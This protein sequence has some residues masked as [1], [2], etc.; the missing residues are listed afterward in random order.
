MNLYQLHSNPESLYGY[1]EAPYRIP[2]IAYEL[3]AKKYRRTGQRDPK[4]ESVIAQ[5]PYRAYL[6]AH[7]F[8]RG[9]WPEGER[10]IAQ[11]PGW[12]CEYALNIIGRRWPRAEP[13]IAQDPWWAYYYAR[14][15]INDRW[16]E[17]ESVIA[18]DPGSWKSYRNRF[19][20]R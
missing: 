6:Y 16:P 19:R 17:A 1:S 11:D 9:R 7:H 5:D 2:S 18:Q 15:V 12:A 13:A 10:V 3:A 20:I 14:N 4:L 8:I